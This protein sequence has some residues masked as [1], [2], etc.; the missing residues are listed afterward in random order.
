[1]VFTHTLSLSNKYNK[2]N[3][4]LNKKDFVGLENDSAVTGTFYSCGRPRSWLLAPTSG[5][6]HLPA[7]PAPRHSLLA[8]LV[9]THTWLVY[10]CMC[11][12]THT[13]P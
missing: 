4:N 3:V 5:G 7:T 8:S 1:M 13:H 9:P 12:Y 2:I 10:A 6:S 11:V